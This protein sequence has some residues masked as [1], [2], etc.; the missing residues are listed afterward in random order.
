MKALL[1]NPEQQSIEAIEIAS[2]DDIVKIIGYDSVIADEIGPD[3]DSLFFDEDC[4]LR[5]T[6]GR[7]QIDNV[8]P[9]SGKGVI[10]GLEADGVT[11][12]DAVSD[13]ES[14]TNRIKYLSKD[15]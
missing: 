3:S 8:I 4:F 9:V 13:V 6:E 10:I 12:K 5:G 7:F 11:L 15:G 2:R 1:I 14:I